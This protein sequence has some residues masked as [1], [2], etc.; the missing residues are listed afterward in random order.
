MRIAIVGTGGVG[1]YFGGKLAAAYVGRQ[2]HEVV[3]IARGEHLLR[4]RGAGLTL[5]TDEG[6]Y[7]VFPSLATDDMTTVGTV[8]LALFCVKDYD[9]RETATEANA[10][11]G[12]HTFVLPLGNGVE[13]RHILESMLSR[14]IVL[15]GLAYIGTHVERPGVISQKGGACKIIF[16]REAEDVGS[17][18]VIRDIFDGANIK[19]DLVADIDV[20]VWTKYIFVCAFSGVTAC[21]GA[22]IGAILENEESKSLLIEVLKE[23]EAIA[24][25]KGVNLPS[26]IVEISVNRAFDFPYQAKTSFQR[27]YERGGKNELEVFNGTIVRLGRELSIP[28]PNN[29]RIYQKLAEPSSSR[30]A[31]S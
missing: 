9:M 16:G 30:G 19:N 8:D 13:G 28:V 20:H 11:V 17:L 27:D 18:G 21:Y 29:E 23:I 5:L 15:N 7:T 3:F 26:D 31:S 14:G 24:R 1:G 2:E 22:S 12:E 6:N 4:I 10:M 25:A